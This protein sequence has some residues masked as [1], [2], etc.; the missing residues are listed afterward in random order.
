MI[1]YGNKEYS[2]Y[3]PVYVHDGDRYRDFIRG[4]WKNIDAVGF[5]TDYLLKS[6]EELTGCELE[7]LQESVKKIS[8]MN[9]P[10]SNYE[11]IPVVIF[12]KS[13]LLYDFLMQ[14]K[15]LFEYDGIEAFFSDLFFLKEGEIICYTISHEGYC[16]IKS[17][18]L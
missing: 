11:T 7:K 16:A 17:E 4:L 12:K 6:K 2:K 10:A 13:F 1:K 14:K 3:E 9:H 8:V 15:G 18:E 5:Q